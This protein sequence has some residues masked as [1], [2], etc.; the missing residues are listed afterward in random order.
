M[1]LRVDPARLEACARDPAF[2]ELYDRVRTQ[3][4]RAMSDGH[5]WYA[6]THADLGTRP[7]AY[8]CAEFGLHNSVPIYSGGLGILAGDHCKAASDLGVPLVAV[9]LLYTKGYF[10]QRVR[11]DGR[12]EDSDEVF[13][14]AVAPLTPV[15]SPGGEPFLTTVET[16]GRQVHVGAWR[17]SV[18]RVPVFLLDTILERNDPEDRLLLH[19]LYA[20][21]ASLRLRQEWI[22]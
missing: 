2:L 5:T 9:G 8:C 1:L 12:Q 17:M 19:K 22:R 11:L 7:I 16:W 6:A 14:P 15:L 18:G 13:D 21:G 4:E 20:G 3:L 10:D